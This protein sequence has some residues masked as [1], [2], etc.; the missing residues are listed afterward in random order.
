MCN[1]ILYK[2][3]FARL[4]NTEQYGANPIGVVFRGS[5]ANFCMCIMVGS[6]TKHRCYKLNYGVLIFHLYLYKNADVNEN[7]FAITITKSK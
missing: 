5:S 4:Y 7:T 3:S 1:P 6:Q 2:I